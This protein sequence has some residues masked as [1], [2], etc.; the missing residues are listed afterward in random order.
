MGLVAKLT[1][2]ATLVGFVID[3][4]LGD[5]AG[6]PHPV[7]LIGRGIS[8]LEKALRRRFPPS[9]RGTLFAGGVM[10]FAVAALSGLVPFCLLVLCQRVSVWLYFGV[11]CVMCWQLFAARCLAN[12]A[13]KVLACLEREGLDAARK[14]VSMLVGRDTQALSEAQVIR[15][16]VE[17]V[18]EN[19]TDGVVAPLFWMLLGGP[20][21]GFVYK[22]INTMDSMVGY[23]NERYLYFGRCAAKLDDAANYIP[24]RL[25]A[26]GMMLAA[27]LAGFDGRNALRIWRRDRRRHA[28]PNAAQTESVC[29]GALHIRLGGNASYFGKLY[30]KPHLGDP[31][32]PVAREDISRSCR[33]MYA[34]SLLLLTVFAAIAL[35]TVFLGG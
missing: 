30:E 34:T 2:L 22:A 26:L 13:K 4:F 15:A 31:D 17:T 7:C 8:F 21:A 16:T 27:V 6:L 14:Q 35:P 29:A 5:P 1:V 25:A 32:R 11:C 9:D 20:A 28:S 10:A 23:K 12:E 19:T 18:A 24:A 33:L 3:C